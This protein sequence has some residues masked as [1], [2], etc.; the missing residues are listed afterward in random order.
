MTD[1]QRREEVHR[2]VSDQYDRYP[3]PAA[4]PNL[5]DFIGR[6]SCQAGCPSQFFHLYWPFREKRLDLD[7]LVAGCGTMQAPKFALNLP[8]ARITAID[9]GENSI[10]H[11]NRLLRLHDI[12]NVATQRMPIEDVGGLGKQFDLVI[13]TGVLHHLPDPAEG[14][15]ALQSVLRP[16]GSMYLMLYGR[17]GRD[18]IYY[19]QDMLRRIGLSAATVTSTELDSIRQLASLLPAYHPLVAKQQFFNQFRVGD[20]ELVDLFLHP[21]DRGYS[22]P[23]I[24]HYL[25]SCNMKLQTMLFRAHYA[26]GCCG[27]AASGLMERISRLPDIEQLA[28]GELYRAAVHMHFFIACRKER[29]ASS[30]LTDLNSPAWK[31]LIPVRS[32]VIRQEPLA[33]TSG[34]RARIYS[35]MHQFSDIGCMLDEAEMALFGLSDNRLTIGEIQAVTATGHA[36]LADDDVVRE[37]YRKMFD[38]DYLSFRGQG[39]TG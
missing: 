30:Y 27:L 35:P 1:K 18:G 7:I 26:P 12:R 34:Y 17:Y 37:F 9:I 31:S 19:L 32:P 33:T 25:D 28:I 4:Q 3:Y 14:L 8:R 21:Q 20:E 36:G 23:D 15:R 39:S 5:A 11:T 22:V 10:H 38:Y 16:D 6:K 13:S 29:P 24:V 2:L